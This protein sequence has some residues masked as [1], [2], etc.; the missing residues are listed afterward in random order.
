MRKWFVVPVVGAMLVTAAACGSGDDGG[1]GSPGEFRIASPI[2]RT[3]SDA[4]VGKFWSTGLDA[5]VSAV[6]AE[7]GIRGRKVVVDYRDTQSNPQTASQVANELLSSNKY[8]AMIPTASN[9]M[10]QPILEAANRYKMLTIGTGP[11]LD[12]SDPKKYPTVFDVKYDAAAQGRATGCLAASYHPKRVAFLHIDDPL[13]IAEIKAMTPDLEKAGAQ[14]V[15]DEAYPFAATDVT[16]QVQKIKQAKPDV[17]V[18][19]AYFNALSTA[20]KAINALDLTGVQIVGDAETAAAPPSSFLAADTPLPK[21]LV[22]M[23]WAINARVDNKLSAAQQAGIQAVSGALGGKFSAVLATYLY[24][25]DALKLVKW[26]AETAKSDKS[27][28][29]VRQ[30][31][32][33]ASTADAAPGTA[34]TAKPPYSPDFHGNRGEMY[35]V[36]IAGEYQSGTFPV[37]SAVPNCSGG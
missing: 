25:Y 8:Q 15:A 37:V 23:Q 16:A 22:A 21:N 33:L 34:V 17:L 13:S 7:G 6:N 12:M 14:V 31:E 20:I 26:A 27:T 18:L 2:D 24:T 35:A 28:D 11:L 19:F 4:A 5:A 36:N 1:S 30:L 29:L 32:T 9:A 3:G 10:S